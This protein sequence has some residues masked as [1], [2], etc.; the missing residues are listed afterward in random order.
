MR[1]IAPLITL[2]AVCAAA[3]DTLLTSP[4][5]DADVFDAPVPGLTDAEMAVFLRGDAAFEEAFSAATG[6]GPIFNDVACAA[7]HSGDGRGRTSNA[8]TRFS[9]GAD[10]ARDLGG[11]QLQDRAILGAIPEVL[12]AG[13]DVS[14]RLPPP[15]FGIGLIEAIPVD[16]ILQHVDSLDADQDGISG[17]PNWVMSAEFVPSTEVGGGSGLQLGRFSRKA[18]VSSVLQQAVEAYHQDM[19]ITTDFLPFE[20]V[21]PQ[22]GAAT[23]AHDFVPDPEVPAST[24]RAVV[25]YVRMLAPPAPGEDTPERRRGSALFD[26]VGCAK[27]HVRQF[28]TGPSNIRALANQDVVLYSDLLLHDM[29]GA[30]ADNRPDGDATGREWRT[31]P[32]WGL[33]LVPDF[34]NG[35]MFLLHDGRAQSIDAAIALHGGEAEQVRLGFDA[36]S[37]ED[38]AALVAFV[39]SR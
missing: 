12:P 31:A 25:D 15:V 6:L 23:L 1:R 11:P 14:V 20:N 17:R 21:N 30:L 33:R 29:G 24:V 38:R 7:C 39:E 10:L 16:A 26:Q 3:C 2:I 22:T 32:L 9:L 13:V 27:C 18:Q 19:G 35:D 28:R 5:A 37:P 4:P 36:L 8:L 34:L